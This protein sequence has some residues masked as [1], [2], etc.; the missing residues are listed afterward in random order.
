[1]DLEALRLLRGPVI[2]WHPAPVPA[3][4]LAFETRV[5]AAI[6]ADIGK[7]GPNFTLFRHPDTCEMVTRDQ[8]GMSVEEWRAR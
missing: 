8:L 5:K 1:M 7:Y 6:A 2:N 3:E 4:R